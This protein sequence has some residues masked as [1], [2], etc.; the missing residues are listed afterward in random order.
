[1]QL[2]SVDQQKSQ[3]LEAHAA[4]FATVK[5]SKQL[6]AGSQGCEALMPP[7]SPQSRAVS[8]G[9]QTCNKDDSPLRISHLWK[10][11]G[12]G[13]SSLCLLRCTEGRQGPQRSSSAT[14]RPNAVAVVMRRKHAV[15]RDHGF[16]ACARSL[17][18]I[19]L[20]WSSPLPPRRSWGAS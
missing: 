6:A 7:A 12:H 18:T 8:P 14:G 1:M 16:V 20:R 2:F 15:V 11:N 5:V 13:S 17:V 4:S 19:P 9:V 10:E 3:A